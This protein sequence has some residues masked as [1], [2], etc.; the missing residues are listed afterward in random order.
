MELK[1]K[2][3]TFPEVIEFNYDDLRQ[4]IIEKVSMYTNLVY[5]DE[6]IK[7]AKSDRSKLNKFVKALSDERIRIKKECLKPYEDFEKKINELTAIVNEPIALIDKQVK[8][9]EE[10]KKSMKLANIQ[11]YFDEVNTHDFLKLD[12]IMNHKWLNASVSMKSIHE[13]INE[14]IKVVAQDIATLSTLPE[15]G[16]EATEVYKTTLDV[17]KAISEAKRMS[18]IAKA[19]AEAEVKKQEVKQTSFNDT[20]SFDACVQEC[21][22]G[23][24]KAT[25]QPKQWVSFSAFLSTEDALALKEFFNSRNIEFKAI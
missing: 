15:F 4:E 20:E 6:Q 3:I 25:G 8:E 16:F 19:K 24:K 13:E 2:Q 22:K 17:N 12:D 11:E 5:T 7:E 1:V 18:E 14:R 9:Y 23:D 21:K 10:L